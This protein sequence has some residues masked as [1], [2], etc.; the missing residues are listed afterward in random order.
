MTMPSVRT[1]LTASVLAL[2]L[3]VGGPCGASVIGL[4]PGDGVDF[5]QID[6]AYPGV[7]QADSQYGLATIDVPALFANTGYGG[8]AGYLNVSTP[9]G[10][11]VRNVPLT[12]SMVGNGYA[13]LSVMFD[14]GDSPG[15]LAVLDAKAALSS[16]PEFAFPVS[17]TEET[18]AVGSIAHDAQGMGAPR[19]DPTAHRIDLTGLPFDPL[20]LTTGIWQP[21]HTNVEQ[22]VNQCGPAS[23]ANSLQYLEDEFGLEVV[24]DNTPGIGA[25]S[26]TLPG[27]L[28]GKMNR[29]QGQTVS[30]DD[31]RDGKVDYLEEFGP[32]DFVSDPDGIPNNGDEM[33]R[34][35]LELKS[36]G[37]GDADSTSGE[38]TMDDQTTSSGLSITEWIFREIAAGEDVEII[39]DWEGVNASHAVEVTGVGAVLGVP[40]ITW[41]H[42]FEQGDNSKG[43]AADEGGH[44]FSWI[45]PATGKVKNFVGTG[46]GSEP[47]PLRNATITHAMSQSVPEPATLG[48][49]AAG[50]ACFLTRR[51]RRR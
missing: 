51:R 25:G 17:V 46:D 10:W 13:G 2:A 3:A 23:V 14:L 43:T 45:D 8:S 36:Y 41:V 34:D 15:A 28:D 26:N 5:A 7:P 24:H 6:L 31:W 19:P 50:A 21:N 27:V 39:L 49:L 44:G 9:E 18:F 42:D 38:T 47:K 48:L 37:F 20:G 4:A 16:D 29:G 30:L 35:T 12:D 22:D 40:F 1:A 33:E 11:V 32:K